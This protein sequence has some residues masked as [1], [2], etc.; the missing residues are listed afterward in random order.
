MENKKEN[1]LK[2]YIADHEEEI[3]I[4]GY[5]L[6]AY[7]IGIGIGRVCFGPSKE[8][9]NIWKTSTR[10]VYPA[11]VPADKVMTALEI[12]GS[13]AFENGEMF[14]IQPTDKVIGTLWC[15]AKTET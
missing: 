4:V 11:M 14:E 12:F 9:K 6:C 5:G 1:K 13:K 2:K 7:L 8:V 3:L 10:G 15:I